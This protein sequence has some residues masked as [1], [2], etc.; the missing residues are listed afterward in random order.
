MNG[1]TK[2]LPNPKPFKIGIWSVRD[3]FKEMIRKPK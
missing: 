1:Q 2:N 3:V